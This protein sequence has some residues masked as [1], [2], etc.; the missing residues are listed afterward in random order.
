MKDMNEVSTR[1]EEISLIE[2]AISDKFNKTVEGENVNKKNS[3]IL[4]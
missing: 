3:Y 4:S 1:Q 2:K